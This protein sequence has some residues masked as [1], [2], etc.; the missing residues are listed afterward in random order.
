ML[1]VRN[2]AVSKAAMELQ[3]ANTIKYSRGAVTIVNRAR[4]EQRACPCY[5]LVKLR[6]AP[7][8]MIELLTF[9]YR[10]R[11]ATQLC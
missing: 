5:R 6:P 10:Q 2:Q 7:P 9:A 4:L 3:E 11:R 8:P 1:G